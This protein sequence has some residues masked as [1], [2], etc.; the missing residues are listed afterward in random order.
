MNTHSVSCQ[1]FNFLEE[2]KEKMIKKISTV[3][4]ATLICLPTLA[5]AG[6][7]SSTDRVA[8]LEKQMADMNKAFNAQMQAMKDEIAALKTKNA[9]M[10][11]EVASTSDAVK[12]S[13]DS[14]EW[15]KKV[16]VGGQLTFRG[17][18]IQNVWDFNDNAD[19]DN[20]SL[21]RTKGSLWA[22]FKPT[23]D[24]TARIQLT[25]QS[26][27]EGVTYTA[28]NPTNDT[29][30]DNNSNKAFLDNAYVNVKNI[31][32]LPVEGTFGRQNLI[33][34]SGFV[35]LDGQSQ[36]ASTSI[37][38]D[39]VKLRWHITDQLMLD[40]L[41]MKDQEN[42]VANSVN[43]NAGDDQTLSGFYLTNKK[44]AI[45]GMQQE[46]YALNRHDE[47]IKKDIWMYGLRLS[48]KLANGIDY[49]LEAAL[50]TGDANATQDQDAWGTK[51]EAGYTFKDLGWKPRF[52]AQYA[53]MSGD[54]SSSAGDNEQWDVYYGGWPQWGDLLA[55][56]YLN[57]GGGNSLNNVYGSYDAQSNV[58][59]EA[60]YSNLQIAGLGASVK[61]IDAVTL[62]I[63][64]SKLT[65][66]ETAAGID[67]D[68]GDYY[69]ASAKYQYNK[70]LSFSLY[71][72]LLAPGDAFNN[73]PKDDATEAYWE[74]EFKF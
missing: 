42:N 60:V 1:L 3:A 17:Y 7:G 2:M 25:N 62:G 13:F 41:Y 49:S 5:S 48:D 64:Y 11:K 29:A 56:K 58:V 72:A 40:G 6:A 35:V 47:A 74:A 53:F 36:F 67:D 55:W 38:F 31:L 54:D 61:P 21:F 19:G 37:Y 69:Q 57:I 44:C 34:G 28:S 24:V 68:F 15:T 32:G 39:G 30:L 16:T 14:A 27:G 50:Q 59:G 52:Y 4:L 9:E 70:Y 10:G 12:K 46:I 33:Y 8:D 23:D 20:R 71:G 45:T 73:T 26:W 43:G 51:L 63:S 65:F 22:D 66:D 18:D